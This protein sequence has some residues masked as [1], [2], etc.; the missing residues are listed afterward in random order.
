MIY[1]YLDIATNS[2]LGYAQYLWHSITNPSF[3]NYFYYLIILSLV[4]WGLEI[5][6]PWRKKQNTI[7]KDFWQDTF[8]MFFN[9]FL[10]SLIGFNALADISVALFNSFLSVFGI[11]N[12]V[13]LQ[14]GSLPNW[15]QF[16]ILFL[17]A[18]FIQWNVH[19]ALHKHPI[20]WKF[21]KTHHSVTEMGFSAHLRY[22]FMETIFYKSALYIPLTMIGYGLD[23][24][25]LLHAFTIL[26]GHLNHSNINITWGP[27]KYILNS[28]TMHIWHHAKGLPK[29]HSTGVNFGI[30]L[31]LWDYIFGTAYTPSSG[32][33]IDLGF[34]DIENY[35]ESFIEQV[36]E[37]FKKRK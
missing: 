10:F 13:A 12:L 36:K 24:L 28:P 1:K 17:V 2:F 23:S 30:S 33:N 25:F 6:F 8:Y 37:P 9:F 32:K 21:H 4:V 35:P 22:H 16:L 11:N 31:S 34:D 26:I 18:D 19:R 27:L 3:D 14:I 15:L 5:A 7:R 20:L 29:N